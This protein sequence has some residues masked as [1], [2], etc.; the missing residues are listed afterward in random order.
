MLRMTA[1]LVFWNVRSWRGRNEVDAMSVTFA[2]PTQEQKIT[3]DPLEMY[4]QGCVQSETS[5]ENFGELWAEIWRPF[6]N[7]QNS[8]QHSYQRNSDA[9][10]EV[11]KNLL[12]VI[13]GKKIKLPSNI[14][15]KLKLLNGNL[16]T[17]Y[18]LTRAYY[19]ILESPS[20]RKDQLEQVKEIRKGISLISFNSVQIYGYIVSGPDKSVIP[21]VVSGIEIICENIIDLERKAFYSIKNK[22]QRREAVETFD[23]AIC[24]AK[25]LLWDFQKLK[26][27]MPISQNDLVNPAPENTNIASV[28]ETIQA[29][30][31]T[32]DEW[33]PVYE[34][35]ATK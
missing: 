24:F 21:S 14:I 6:I 32:Y 25:S 18:T 35:L 8:G 27:D 1:L 15:H 7:Y 16:I 13:E 30:R 3:P 2:L 12:E 17:A 23:E 19:H 4:R 31:E 22:K 11:R 29:F 34:S 10:L 33:S 5:V 20:R 9:I 26:K 28:D